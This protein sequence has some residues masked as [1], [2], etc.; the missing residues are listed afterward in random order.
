MLF[1]PRIRFKRP[2]FLELGVGIAV[3]I[4]C[5]AGTGI[6]LKY[7]GE[8][9]PVQDWLAWHLLKLLGWTAILNG[10]LVAVG[11]SFLRRVMRSS[12]LPPA[13]LVLLSMTVGLS[14]FAL[15]MYLAGALFLYGGVFAAALPL[16]FLAIGARDLPQLVR[17]CWSDRRPPAQKSLIGKMFAPLAAGFGATMVTFLYL[18][19][20]SPQGF[21][22]DAIWYHVPVAQDYAREGG[23]IP[24]YGDN[25][26]AY[27][28]LTS[29][30]QTWALLVPGIEPLPVRWMLMLHL[31]FSFV[32][33]RIV[34]AVATTQWLL[35]GRS[36]PGMWAVFFLFPSVFIYDQN[37]AGSADHVLGATAVPIFLGT[38]RLFRRFEMKWA[39]VTGIAAGCHILTKYQA[40]YMV[41]AVAGLVGGRCLWGLTRHAYAALRKRSSSELPLRSLLVAPSLVLGCALLVSGPHFVKNWAFYDN[42]VYPFASKLFPSDFE[43]WEE[44]KVNVHS[45]RAQGDPDEDIAL[46]ALG[47]GEKG[48]DDA[49]PVKARGSRVPPV[50][51][52][53]ASHED[54][55]EE[56]VQKVEK[57]WAE[58]FRFPPRA[59]DFGPQGE[60]VLE[61]LVWVHKTLLDW[62]FKTGNRH[63]TKQLP[64]MG[65]LFT[66]LLP[67]LLFLRRARR[68]WFCA[69]FLYL[70]FGTWALTIANDRYLVSF[71][72]IPI[73]MAGALLARAWHLG[74]WPRLGLVPLVAIQLFWT[75]D[76]P[77]HY[78]ERAFKD[79]VRIIDRGYS[80]GGADDRF[81][82][83]EREQRLTREFPPDALILGRYFKDQLGFDRATLNTH[84]AIQKYIRFDRMHSVREFWQVAKDRGVTHLLY[85]VGKRKPHWAQDIVLFDALVLASKNQKSQGGYMMAELSDEPPED[86]GP[87]RVLV[88]G[89]REYEDGLYLVTKLSVDERSG[90]RN[91]RAPAK[92]FKFSEA[93]AEKLLD[94]AGAVLMNGSK[95]KDDADEKLR[96]EFHRVERFG[97]LGVYLRKR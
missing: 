28:Q 14:G 2:N 26:R 22:F 12:D 4:V 7:V 57:T 87:L 95:L 59:Y 88:L 64:Y 19:C 33:W 93:N 46:S 81:R 69:G 5:L 11:F 41:V 76:A 8:F 40:L 82:Y 34:G 54:P 58:R 18:S 20:L 25:H 86:T 70:A 61:R 77:L 45:L 27:P 36:V 60:G 62:S 67:I 90:K 53:S 1:L 66:L 72:S 6:F 75:I 92:R 79:A 85:P 21:N 50:P 23:I 91:A 74:V 13:E 63:L 15:T 10:S 3:L 80:R 42:P 71:L 78:G 31:E 49:V 96:R 47:S 30:L 48:G 24:F 94:A 51:R 84:R 37:I 29:L 89:V 39:I 32:L 44:T 17:Q 16:L 73:G 9:Y 35:A 52:T 55:S 65:S 56:G 68:L 83:R 43:Q 97:P 38:A